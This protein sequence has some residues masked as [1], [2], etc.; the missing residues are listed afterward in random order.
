MH[1]VLATDWTT[2]Y[3]I[4]EI[5]SSTHGHLDQEVLLLVYMLASK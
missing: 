4:H 1:L 5:L 3:G 2:Q